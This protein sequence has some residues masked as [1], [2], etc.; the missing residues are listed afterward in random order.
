MSDPPVFHEASGTVRFWVLID[1]AH[2]GASIGKETLH[3][4]YRPT[5][6]DDT[7]LETFELHAAEIDAAV[8]KRVLG[9]SKEPVMLRELDLK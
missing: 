3:Y 7:P 1:G 5:A 8:R 6:S 9:G 4:H 2:V